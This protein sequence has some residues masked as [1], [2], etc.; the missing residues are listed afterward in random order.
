[1]MPQNPGDREHVNGA[2]AG[3]GLAIHHLSE[4]EAGTLEARQKI[5]E[6]LRDCFAQIED[7]W[8]SG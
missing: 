1:M 6:A 5:A 8:K 3:I 2:L 7:L 4:M